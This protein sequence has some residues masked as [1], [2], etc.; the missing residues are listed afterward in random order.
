MRYAH[1]SWVGRFPSRWILVA[2]CDVG[3]ASL[4]ILSPPESSPRCVCILRN[5][6]AGWD[7]RCR[8]SFEQFPPS[9]YSSCASYGLLAAAYRRR[10]YSHRRRMLWSPSRRGWFSGPEVGATLF[11][12]TH[13][14]LVRRTGPLLQ[15]Q[16]SSP[17]EERKS[18]LLS[19]WLW[20]S[21]PRFGVSLLA[22]IEERLLFTNTHTTREQIRHHTSRLLRRSCTSECLL[23]F[24]SFVLLCRVFRRSAVGHRRAGDGARGR[25]GRI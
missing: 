22:E 12:W 24:G 5:C 2:W 14:E 21:A 17:S 8:P 19:L 11:R 1:G 20:P 9:P 15:E 4:S 13:S 25:S 7:H 16:R 6:W 10:N 3:T 18:C 23:L